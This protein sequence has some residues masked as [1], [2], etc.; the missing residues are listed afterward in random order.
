MKLEG[1]LVFFLALVL[2]AGTASAEWV[3]VTADAEILNN[4]VETAKLS[5]YKNALREA[6]LLVGAT[7]NSNTAVTNGVLQSDSVGVSSAARIKRANII[8][9]KV[10]EKKVVVT[11]SAD[12]VSESVCPSG[13][14]N[15]YKKEV[16]VLGFSVQYPRQAILGALN[17]IDRKLPSY[18]KERLHE[19]DNLVV[20]ESS[21]YQLYDEP[22][23]APTT[24]TSQRTL[25]KVVQ[26]AQQMGV[27]FIV[28]GIV[29]DLS[30]ADETAFG[31]SVW[32]ATKRF[33]RMADRN[34]RFVVD[35]FIHDGFSGSI[36]F[37]KSYRL[38]DVWN[39][40]PNE[41]TGFASASFF[42]T[43]YGKGVAEL[44]EGA[45]QEVNGAMRCQPFMARITR[46]DGKT[47]HFA[48]GAAAGIRP[49]DQL[50]VY[51]TYRF[52]DADLLAG[53]ELTNA[54][55]ALTVSQVHP[56]FST[57][58][59]SVDS[60]RLNIQPDDLLIAW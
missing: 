38:T 15:G 41:S 39:A 33:W 43:P 46:T 17:D 1:M 32:S 57:G 50:A 53:T 24:E 31:N 55:A 40:D 22:I 8:E 52:Y 28:S 9:E 35:V 19:R 45:A 12:V 37:Q 25:T 49:G 44:L 26:Y 60:G 20:H 51:R 36:V 48:S 58:T 13:A 14:A 7:V 30:V 18:L 5:A 56:S 6:S 54:K 11:V 16:A 34:R 29:R 21:Q 10:T 47:V 27:Q 42:K 23:N 59:I 2:G 3:T 4:D